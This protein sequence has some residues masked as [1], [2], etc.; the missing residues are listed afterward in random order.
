MGFQSWRH[1]DHLQWIY[2]PLEVTWTSLSILL[3][4]L[5]ISMLARK[6]FLLLG[7][8]PKFYILIK[9]ITA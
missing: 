7:S 6:K 5:T 1:L 9:V 3:L 8:S 2:L 4:I